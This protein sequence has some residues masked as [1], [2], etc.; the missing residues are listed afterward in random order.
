MKLTV[1]K[2]KN[3]ASLYVTKSFYDSGVRTSK[4]IEKLGTEAELREKLGGRDPYEWAQEYVDGLT[5]EEKEKRAEQPD[6]LIKYSQT[7]LIR[8]DERRLFNCGYLFLQRIYHAAGLDKICG[9][10]ADRHKFRF[11]LDSIL[12]RLAY[13]R[14]IYPSSKLATMELSK[15]FIEQPNFELH[16]IYRALEA[17][18]AES[19]F[20]QAQLY[21]KTVLGLSKRDTGVLYYDCTNFFFEIE[22][23]AG[24]KQYSAN[25]K[26][27]KPNPLVQMGLFMDGDG[28]PLAYCITA[29]NKNEQKTLRPLEQK[30]LSDFGVAKFVV[31]TD[32]GLSS[33]ANRKF[34]DM[35]G[36]AYITTQSVKK[37][38]GYLKGWALFSEHWHLPGDNEDYDIG[39]LYKSEGEENHMDANAYRDRVFY[40]E[41]WINDDGLRQRLVVTFSLKYRDYQRKIRGGQVARAEELVRSRPTKLKKSH[42]NDYKRFVL[43]K[44]VTADGEEA[45]RTVFSIDEDQ[46]AKEEAYD[47]FYA[48]CTNLEDDVQEIIKVNRRR[49]EIEESFRIMK[50]E[51]K[52]RPV[53]L[54]RD[55]RIEAH[56]ATCFISLVIFRY[57]EKFLGEKFTCCEIVDALRGM[58]MLDSKGDG[59]IPAYTRTDLTDALHDMLGE[60]TDTQIVTKRKMKEII[61]ASKR[62]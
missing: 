56:F 6:I 9:R 38:K 22:Q 58:G 46:I 19:D 28:I 32:A 31:C 26:D 7:K 21:K 2:S 34:N 18:A 51:F 53:Y 40:K 16:H 35:G 15:K 36:R 54:R 30:I 20:I 44:S 42:P 17:I 37:L 27:H 29:G 14:V 33:L 47:G 3:A 45:K 50:H 41:R 43:R 10:I 59:Y 57:L 13:S 48:V 25:G 61:K 8:K 62:K 11:D 5:R 52:A 24:L 49:W 55:D 23:E 1:S 60:R 39:G 4:I 12:S